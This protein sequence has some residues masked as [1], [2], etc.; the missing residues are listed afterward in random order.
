[1]CHTDLQ[2]DI[3]HSHQIERVLFCASF[4]YE[5]LVHLSWNWTPNRL[6]HENGKRTMV[7]DGVVVDF[8]LGV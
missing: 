8:G 6:R 3:S 7:G 4:S 5:F 2:Q 1:V